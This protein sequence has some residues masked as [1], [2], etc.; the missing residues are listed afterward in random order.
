M[1]R[2]NTEKLSIEGKG[3]ES[4]LKIIE[5]LVFVLPIFIVCYLFYSNNIFLSFSQ[6][7]IIILTLMSILG[8]LIILHQIFDGFLKVSNFIKTANTCKTSSIYLKDNTA[9]LHQITISFKNLMKNFEKTTEELNRKVSELSSIK[10]FTEAASKNSN[11]DDLLSVLLEKAMRLSKAKSGFVLMVEPEKQHLR[12]VASRGIKSG[13]KIGTYTNMD[14]S[15]A[16]VVISKKKPLLVQDIETDPRTQKENDPKYGPPSFI[17]MPVF[18]GENL[19]SVLNLS[20]KETKEVFDSNDEHI[21][22]I[23]IDEFGFALENAQLHS[24]VEEHKRNLQECTEELAN[25]NCQLRQAQKMEAIGTLTG[26]IT[27]DFNN[28]LAAIIGYTDLA[29]IDIPDGSKARYN[30]LEAKKAIRRAKE[31]VNQILTFSR[32]SEQK[33]IPVKISIIIKEALKLLRAS[34]PTTIEIHK[35]IERDTGTI[36]ADPTQVHQVL[37]NLCTNAG[38]AMRE[39]GG[40]ILDVRLRNVSISKKSEIDLDPGPYVKLTVS[41]TGHGIT[42]DVLERIFDPFFTTKEKGEGTGLGLS[43]VHGIVKDHGGTITVESEPE[44]GTTFHIFFPR[45]EEAEKGADKV[46]DEPLPNGQERILFIDDEF[47]LVDIGKQMLEYLGYKVTIKTDSLEAL[48]LF[49]E[50]PHEFDLVITDM[51]MP[52][53]TGEKLAKEF[54]RIRPDVPIILCTGFCGQNTEENAKEIGIKEFAMKPLMMEDLAKT[55]RKVLNI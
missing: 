52:N 1:A 48:K 4:K 5:A 42:P 16:Q 17:I 20:H 38:H 44:K 15:L 41:D 22:S 14:E 27:H 13:A 55:I 3:L 24:T 9:E 21:L 39:N 11:I 46:A 36:K 18:V 25:A 43:L 19:I 35:H 37:M 26:G 53:M 47:A 7:V 50:Q 12:F 30:L 29:I 40:G 32:Q 45:I 33:L 54:I 2:F 31:L 10:E 51:T 8:G 6:I 49:Q 23:M 28:I 34:L